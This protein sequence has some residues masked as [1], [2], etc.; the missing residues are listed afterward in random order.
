[1]HFVHASNTAVPVVIPPRHARALRGRRS[2]DILGI[3]CVI[4][5][6]CWGITPFTKKHRKTFCDTSRKICVMTLARFAL[7]RACRARLPEDFFDTSR[8][9]CVMTGSPV[10]PPRGLFVTPLARFALG[11]ACRARLPE[12]SL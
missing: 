9:I 7:G 5:A 8:T 2:E 11:R 10:E 4:D 3:V 1:M 12:D 6:K